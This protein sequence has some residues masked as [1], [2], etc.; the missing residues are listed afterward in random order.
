MVDSKS[1]WALKVRKRR[2]NKKI[3]E[4]KEKKRKEGKERKG[5]ERKG[6]ERKGKKRKGKERNEKI[7]QRA[8][9]KREGSTLLGEGVLDLEEKEIKVS[10]IFLRKLWN[11]LCK[12]LVL[13]WTGLSNFIAKH[14]VW[15]GILNRKHELLSLK[16]GLLFLF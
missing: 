10:L 9:L 13:G 11:F 5:K 8:I 16:E 3:K 4:K 7:F 14:P 12:D 1:S 6:K 15:E 2:K